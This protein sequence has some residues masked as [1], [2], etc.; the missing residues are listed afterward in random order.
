MN[1]QKMKRTNIPDG[2][3][4]TGIRKGGHVMIRCT[5]NVLVED[6]YVQ[7]IF[8]TRNCK[9]P[10]NHVCH[11]VIKTPVEEQR[12]DIKKDVAHFIGKAN[13]AL[14]VVEQDYFNDFMESL[15]ELGQRNPTTPAKSLIPTLNR[16]NIR[17][18]VV[19]A[20]EETFNKK[21]EQVHNDP[22]ITV[23]I[24][25][26]TLS[27]RHM[28]DICLT[29]PSLKPMFYKSIEK[30]TAGMEDYMEI[31]EAELIEIFQKYKIN[32][33]ALVTD[34]L[35]VQVMALAHWSPTSIL[36]TSKDPR[37]RKIIFFRMSLPFHTIDR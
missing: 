17:P 7:C 6:T 8:T 27:H 3:E 25:A 2:F 1:M 30:Q 23:S 36:N 28:I 15:I 12:I 37:I 13:L 34:N 19:K 11:G 20:G 21:I 24:D 32:V 35:P 14:R 33:V 29:S 16:K 22:A 31:T 26:G 4:D 18:E 10:P 5:K 9:D